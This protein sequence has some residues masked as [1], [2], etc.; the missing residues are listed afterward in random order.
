MTFMTLIIGAANILLA[1]VIYVIVRRMW[2]D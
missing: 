2:Q 1:A